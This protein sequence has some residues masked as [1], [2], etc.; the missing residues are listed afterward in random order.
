MTS[1]KAL[2]MNQ[3][4]HAFAECDRSGIRQDLFIT[5]HRAEARSKL[6]ETERALCLRKVITDKQWGSAGRTKILQQRVRKRFAAGR[7]RTLQVR[8]CRS[9]FIVSTSRR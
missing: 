1:A 5:P 8:D 7:T 3:R 9:H 4:R 2:R 6:I